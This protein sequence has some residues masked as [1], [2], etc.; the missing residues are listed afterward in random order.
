MS[1][2]PTQL[3]IQERL[4]QLR[5]TFQTGSSADTLPLVLDWPR[6][7][8]Q[9]VLVSL[10]AERD[11][12][13]GMRFSRNVSDMDRYHRYGFNSESVEIDGRLVRIR[14][15]RVRGLVNSTSHKVE[16]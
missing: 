6:L 7:Q 9:I 8:L 13:C 16:Q 11:A 5:D 12:V 3:S 4:E 2:L 1:T 14:V 10:E 15:P